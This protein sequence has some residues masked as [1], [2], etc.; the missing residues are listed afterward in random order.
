[1]KYI[2]CICVAVKY[3]VRCPECYWKNLANCNRL[4]R[5]TSTRTDI[6]VYSKKPHN[7]R[8]REKKNQQRKIVQMKYDSMFFFYFILST[9]CIVFICFNLHIFI[10]S[11]RDVRLFAI[12]SYKPSNNKFLNKKK[13]PSSCRLN[14]TRQKQ[15]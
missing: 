1:M 6:Y 9:K 12:I 8:D 11:T 5:K 7:R 4:F 3:I 2:Y 13:M 14:N 10:Q 15:Q